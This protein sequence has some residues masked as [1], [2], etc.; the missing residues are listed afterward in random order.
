[1]KLHLMKHRRVLHAE[2]QPMT[3]PFMPKEEWG[4]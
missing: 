1:M 4:A 2:A 3:L